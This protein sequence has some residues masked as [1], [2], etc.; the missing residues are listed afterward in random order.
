M[1]TTQ[2]GFEREERLDRPARAASSGSVSR[3]E[4]SVAPS[5]CTR[6]GCT[7]RTKPASA[8]PG[9][10]MRWMVMRRPSPDSPASS[11]SRSSALSSS[12]DRTVSVGVMLAT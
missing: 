6:S 5:T 4:I 9:F 2:A 12:S 1:T 10:W 11:T 3:Y 7:C 8:R